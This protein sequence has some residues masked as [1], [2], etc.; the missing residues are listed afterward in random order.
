[1]K[2][3]LYIKYIFTGIVLLVANTAIRASE[4][5]D[6]LLQ[7]A[8]KAS[9]EKNY[10]QSLEILYQAQ[11]TANQKGTDEQRFW[12]LTNIGINYAELMD[13]ST[14]L[15]N[16]SAAYKLACNSLD[17]RHKLSVSSNIAGV[18]MLDKKYD[19]ALE[20][21]KIIYKTTQ[22][23]NDSLFLGGCAM[24]IA[25]ASMRLDDLE[26]A[27]Q[28]ID[29]AEQMFVGDTINTM[30]LQILKANFFRKRGQFK[31]SYEIALHLINTARS[32]QNKRFETEGLILL[33][34]TMYDL[35]EYHATI[36]YADEALQNNISIEE[37]KNLYNTL[38][39]ANFELRRYKQS[40]AYKDSVIQMSDSIWNTHEERQFENANI[41]IE[42]LKRENE[43]EEYRLR[44]RTSYIILGLGL[45]AGL[46]LAWALV[47]QIIKNRQEKQIS[48]L[49][50][51]R[52]KQQQKLLQNQLEEQRTQAL[53][54]EERYKHEI[55]IRDKELMSKAMIVANRNDI[56]A[57]IIETLS[58]TKS[59]KESNDSNLKHTISQLQHTLDEN[60]AW[61]DFTTYFEQRNDA[62]IGALRERHP[63]LNANEIRFLSLVYINLSTKEIASLLNITP[64]YCKKK[65]QQIARK[66][67]FENSKALFAYLSTL[68]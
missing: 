57:N 23:S 50:I 33:A 59:I 22:K 27:K 65:R 40:F 47:N 7:T 28:Y 46:I 14:A 31:E 9:M 63:E 13:Y 58:N 64:E 42:L 3:K 21:F 36:R 5:C 51:E 4:Q 35:R 1:M 32:L 20:Q 34:Y 67:G 45:F 66:M 2:S 11:E 49:E 12:I 10:R 18:Y 6:S 53:F 61:E 17:E 62:F 52:E 39:Q 56:I 48:Q 44:T 54:E 26:Q 16:L 60:T 29:V 24:N 30:E 55:E 25:N 68:T 41:Q 15:D 37:R 8:I 38:S 43:I 19:K